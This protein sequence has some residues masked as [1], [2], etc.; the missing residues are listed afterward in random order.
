MGQKCERDTKEDMYCLV[1]F[2]Q[3]PGYYAPKNIISNNC[4]QTQTFLPV[5]P[6][7]Q[8]NN[9]N[10]IDTNVKKMEYEGKDSYPK[11][12]EL[13]EN[14][15]LNDIISQIIPS[16]EFESK[17]IENT[18]AQPNQVKIIETSSVNNFV[19]ESSQSII[20]SS[21]F[22]EIL[23]TE[24]DPIPV[25]TDTS[26]DLNKMENKSTETDTIT[27]KGSI[28]SEN[29]QIALQQTVYNTEVTSESKNLKEESVSATAG[30]SVNC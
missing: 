11:K 6:K 5:M 12:T 13:S 30:E 4:T 25:G 22:Q 9:I 14:D 10:K 8:S 23:A 16:E 15:I 7:Y 26:V 3:E 27:G 29:Q 2:F 19:D 20:A 28:E 21:T 1:K 18:E 24:D 17:Q